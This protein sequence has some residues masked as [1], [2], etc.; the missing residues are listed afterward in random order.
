MKKIFFWPYQLYVWLVFVPLA[1]VV[2]LT[3]GLLTALFA[4][5]VSPRFASRYF[6]A[7][8]ARILAFLTPMR[9]SVKGAEHALRA[10]SYVVVCNHQSQYDILLVYGYLDLDLKWVMKQELRKIPGIGIGCEK[11]GHIFIDRQNPRSARAAVTA[12]LDRLGEGVGILFFAEGTRS[13]DGRLQPFKKGAFR[14]AIEQQLPVLPVTLLGTRD[15]LPAR[16]LRLF[17]GRG[18]M[19]IHPAIETAGMGMEQLEDLMQR[20]REAI[21]SAMPAGLS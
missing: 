6:A 12:A 3:C 8:W 19:V 14:L 20:A 7:P 1:A 2:T 21:A 4:T 17:P 15:I 10:R 13:L 5:V 18:T 9:V 16:T 11:A